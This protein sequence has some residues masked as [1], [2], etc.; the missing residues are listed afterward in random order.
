[1][2]EQL[3]KLIKAGDLNGLKQYY[4][5]GKNLKTINTPFSLCHNKSTIV[6]G[7]FR[8]DPHEQQFTALSY[9]AVL[10]HLHIV[11]YLLSLGAE[12]AITVPSKEVTVHDE[13][14]LNALAAHALMDILDWNHEPNNAIVL[15]LVKHAK[16]LNPSVFIT[17]G[18]FHLG[19]RRSILNHLLDHD[20][21]RPQKIDI[22]HNI[23]L[24]AI[25]RSDI[26]QLSDLITDLVT[27]GAWVKLSNNIYLDFF[28]SRAIKHVEAKQ[29]LTSLQWMA[30]HMH[31]SNEQYQ[32]LARQIETRYLYTGLAEP[33][34][35]DLQSLLQTSRFPLQELYAAFLHYFL[36]DEN[37]PYLPIKSR[38]NSI[39][40][41]EYVDDENRQ[42][43][44]NQM[45]AKQDPACLP[46]L[47]TMN[48][49][50]FR[51]RL[52]MNHEENGP[53]QA[54]LLLAEILLHHAKTKVVM[55]GK[56]RTLLTYDEMAKALQLINTS[57]QLTPAERMT[58]VSYKHQLMETR[59]HRR[60]AI[61]H[62]SQH[63]QLKQQMD[64]LLAMMPQLTLQPKPAA[65][66]S[67][68]RRTLF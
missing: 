16:M 54:A 36:P 50:E 21:N 47:L 51:M 42:A 38:G 45:C 24:E 2:S 41:D 10:G 53:N 6:S 48:P 44:I 55:N 56:E 19:N 25:V 63:K 32:E 14:T 46:S 27:R 22:I 57:Y 37:L 7:N 65:T 1:M 26:V 8:Y 31:I 59:A 5:E 52:A 58:V 60:E 68:P 12:I 35:P 43:W 39:N 20:R 13:F 18:L 28:E 15:L 40:L 17:P 64:Q 23:V 4:A 9:A 30:Y 29:A 34:P 67:P 3:I 33:L 66:S 62:Q 49:Y 61:I 11:E